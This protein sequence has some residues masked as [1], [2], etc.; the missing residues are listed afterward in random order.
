VFRR[1]GDFLADF[2]P[3]LPGFRSTGRRRSKWTRQR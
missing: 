1:A 3:E 2:V